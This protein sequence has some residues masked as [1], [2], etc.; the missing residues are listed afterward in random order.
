M[1]N[2]TTAI[3][4]FILSC[5]LALTTASAEI[6]P[7]TIDGKK[8]DWVG[9]TPSYNDIQG[10][11]SCGSADTDLRYVYTAIDDQYAYV[12]VETWGIPINPSA[13]LE[14]NFDYMP[15]SRDP[16]GSSAELHTNITPSGFYAFVDDGQTFNISDYSIAYGDVLEMRIPLSEI[17]G[18]QYFRVTRGY[19]HFNG[20]ACDGDWQIGTGIRYVSIQHRNYQ[21]GR[22]FNK[23]SFPLADDSGGMISSPVADSVTLYDPNGQVVHLTDIGFDTSELLNGTYD[24]TTGQFS[25]SS[26]WAIQATNNY[27]FDGDM[28]QGIYHLVVTVPGYPTFENFY[29]YNGQFEM[30]IVLSESFDASFNSN[31]DLIWTWTPPLDLNPSL[32]TS[33]RAMVQS[34]TNDVF[35]KRL[36]H[37]KLPSHMGYLY[38]PQNIV[39]FFRTTGD[40]LHLLIGLRSNDDKNRTY[41]NSIPMDQATGPLKGDFDGDGKISIEEAIYALKIASGIQSE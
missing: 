38:V 37:V 36:I 11:S 7:I 8:S 30:P 39:N 40:T 28:I 34:K 1:R 2:R 5:F 14:L 32:S 22:E 25:Y 20:R 17:P 27:S 21:D 35:T 26:N 3:V 41:S 12:M 33:I 4:A 29:S 31:G 18:A 23:L 15:G 10:D 24:G 16:W 13:I 9:F 19:L 6:L